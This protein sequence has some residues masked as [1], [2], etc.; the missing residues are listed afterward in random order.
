MLPKNPPCLNQS[1]P[2]TNVN[3][4]WSETSKELNTSGLSGNIR[5]PRTKSCSWL[6]LR[7]GFSEVQNCNSSHSETT[8]SKDNQDTAKRKVFRQHPLFPFFTIIKQI[9]RVKLV[10]LT[11]LCYI[12]ARNR[13]TLCEA[14]S[15][16]R[17]RQFWALSWESGCH[18]RHLPLFPLKTGLHITLSQHCAAA[19]LCSFVAPGIRVGPTCQQTVF[20]TRHPRAG[21]KLLSFAAQR[22]TLASRPASQQHL[23]LPPVCSVALRETLLPRAWK[24]QTEGVCIWKA[25]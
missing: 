16:L 24:R 13:R 3:V 11:A 21:E 8:E 1:D 22:C 9:S 10:Q 17:L 4:D 14:M 15:I 19:P 7:F 6:V 18:H 23:P 20:N 2:S 5:E 25:K 12:G